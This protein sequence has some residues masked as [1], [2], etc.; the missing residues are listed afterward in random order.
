MHHPAHTEAGRDQ[1]LEISESYPPTPDPQS[2]MPDPDGQERAKR[3]ASALSLAYNVLFT[4]A[5]LVAALLTGSMSLL[6]EALHSATDIVASTLAYVGVRA[7]SAPPDERHPYG[8]GKIETLAGFGESILL[9]L[10]VLYLI[11][12]GIHRLIR[13]VQLASLEL[14]VL[15]MALSTLSSL[16][17][18][19]YVLRVGRRTRSLALL[20]NGQHLMVDFWTSAS[21]LLALLLIRFTGWTPIDPLLAIGIALWLLRGAWRL[22]TQAFHELIDQRLPDEE[23]AHIDRL[24]CSDPRV[25][26][27]HNLRTRRAGAI[28]Y[29][30]LHIVVPA[31]WSLQQAHAVADEL[32]K[33]LERELCPAQVVIHVDPYDPQKA[34]PR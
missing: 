19:Q 30:D 20:S 11:G 28:R 25:I 33:R 5:K 12:E 10:M 2:L 24:I 4:V 23:I 31:D 9:F 16:V 17:V 8:H 1:A 26:S 32:E 3:R 13:G 29:I 21:V 15:V 27:Y 6:S 22:S 34:Q 14:G 18:G 7:A